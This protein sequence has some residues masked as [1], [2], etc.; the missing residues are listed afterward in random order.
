MSNS[1]PDP[2][3]QQT[4]EPAGSGNGEVDPLERLHKMSRTAGVGTQDYVA[5]NSVS[6]AAMMLGIASALALLDR[7]L[8]IV[9]LAGVICAIVALRQIVHSGGT[10][11]GRSLAW[12]GLVLCLLFA[13]GQI[14]RQIIGGVRTA[15]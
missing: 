15:R 4:L 12:I 3:Q 13:G 6:V 7:T 9:P 10:Q 2:K 1:P 8:L 5:V 11:T 14:A